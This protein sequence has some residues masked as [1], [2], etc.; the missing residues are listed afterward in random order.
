MGGGGGEEKDWQNHKFTMWADLES[1]NA[2]KKSDLE[3]Q[4]SAFV[5]LP[6]FTVFEW[7]FLFIE[8][9]LYLYKCFSAAFRL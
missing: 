8:P 2:G 1:K 3:K 6:N 7:S 5:F 9:F 4:W